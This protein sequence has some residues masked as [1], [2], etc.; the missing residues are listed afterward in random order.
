[1]PRLF[2]PGCP[3]CSHQFSNAI[4]NRAGPALQR[5]IDAAQN[6]NKA[7][8]I[9]AGKAS[10]P[11]HISTE[12]DRLEA[13]APLK[14]RSLG[15]ARELSVL[16]HR[17]FHHQPNAQHNMRNH[18]TACKRLFS[19]VHNVMYGQNAD[20]CPLK[21]QGTLR[22]MGE[23]SHRKTTIRVLFRERSFASGQ[24]EKYRHFSYHHPSGAS[25]G[26]CD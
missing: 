23:S 25:S 7:L 18:P 4:G 14:A 21:G 2:S 5:A 3:P 22:L 10:Q 6:A 8:F 19:L 17:G 12:E 13:K 15:S 16:G 26:R 1:M 24:I 11:L 20:T 9:P